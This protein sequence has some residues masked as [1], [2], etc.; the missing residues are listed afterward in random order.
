MRD[1]ASVE[2]DDDDREV[3]ID[4]VEGDVFVCLGSG[5]LR[6]LFLPAAADACEEGGVTCSDT[7]SASFFVSAEAVLPLETLALGGRGSFG[8]A[9]FLMGGCGLEGVMLFITAAGFGGG[10]GGGVGAGTGVSVSVL[11]SA[12]DLLS[13]FESTL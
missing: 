4:C 9:G 7:F 3:G 1:G 8:G 13:D 11:P 10:V 12:V 2:R 6:F 5:V